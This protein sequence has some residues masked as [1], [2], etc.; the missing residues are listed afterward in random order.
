MLQYTGDLDA[1]AL[2]TAI[3]TLSKRHPNIR[4]YYRTENGVPYKFISTSFKL[5]MQTI[6]PLYSDDQN[7]DQLAK[8]EIEK[9]AVI[10][11]DFENGP[12]IR[13]ILITGM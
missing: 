9:H 12:L 11:F 1:N 10:P 5:N 3:H 4:A 13:I 7:F 8:I 6:A 2:N